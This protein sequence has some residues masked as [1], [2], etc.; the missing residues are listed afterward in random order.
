M[1]LSERSLRSGNQIRE[2]LKYMRIGIVNSLVVSLL[3]LLGCTHP[4]EK[5]DLSRYLSDKD[6]Q[7][8][9]A[10]TC[11]LDYMMT[12]VVCAAEVQ[13]VNVDWSSVGDIDSRYRNGCRPVVE[14]SVEF[15]PNG[16]ARSI[17][18]GESVAYI[19][20]L[21][22]SYSMGSWRGAIAFVGGGSEFRIL[23]FVEETDG[24]LRLTKIVKLPPTVE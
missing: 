15:L 19:R 8:I 7:R 18:S 12:N 6:P 22:V 10:S 11:M 23:L 17:V 5:N 24:A 13:A 9:A 16:F 4:C 3:L 21:G 14:G 2:E 20:D 1:P